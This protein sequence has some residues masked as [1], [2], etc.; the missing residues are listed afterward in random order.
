M[1]ALDGTQEL[2][3][4]RKERRVRAVRGKNLLYICHDR[5]GEVA[6]V[7]QKLPLL[8]NYINDNLCVDE[9]QTVTVTGL[10]MNCD[11]TSNKVGGYH[12]NRWRVRSIGLEQATDEINGLR[13]QF[14][15]VIVVTEDPKCYSF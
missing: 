8:R 3:G 1:W 6:L 15:K 12:K 5:A 11:F 2:T 14:G 9:W 13:A 7:S 4:I 10:Y